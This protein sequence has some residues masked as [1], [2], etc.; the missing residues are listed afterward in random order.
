M[1]AR[2]AWIYPAGPLGIL[3]LS[4]VVLSMEAIGSSSLVS[5]DVETDGNAAQ[6]SSWTITTSE[7]V[8]Y[9]AASIAEPECTCF[10][11][12]ISDAAGAANSAGVRLLALGFE[13]TSPGGIRRVTD[14]ERK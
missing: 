6:S 12:T 1:Y 4:E 2:T 11:V 10:R 3:R 9:R 13:T 14:S 7:A 5:L 8:S